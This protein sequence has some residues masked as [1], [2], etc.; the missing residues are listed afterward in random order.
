MEMN[1]FQGYYKKFIRTRKMFENGKRHDIMFALAS[2][3][4]KLIG[5]CVRCGN[6]KRVA[7]KFDA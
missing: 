5:L 7:L 3:L 6:R 1:F 4:V 2:R